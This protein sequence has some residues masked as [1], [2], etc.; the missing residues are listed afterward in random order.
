MDQP[1]GFVDPS[2][3]DY[4]CRLNRSLYGLKQAPR[5]WFSRLATFLRHHKF[6][7]S[8]ADSSLFLR[9]QGAHSVYILIYV[10]DIVITGSSTAQITQLIAALHTEFPVKDLGKLHYFL[11]IEVSYT[12]DGIFLS[13]NWYA[14]DLIHQAGLHTSNPCKTPMALSPKLTKT[15][16]HNLSND[17]EYRRFVGALQYLTITRPDIAFTVNKLCQFMHNP[18]HYIGRYYNDSYVTFTAVLILGFI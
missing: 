13:Q 9:R 15:T 12:A 7:Q 10:D 6:V 18:P 16:G 17:T 8:R 5:E 14:L 1:I 11:G 3:P 2:R 4:V